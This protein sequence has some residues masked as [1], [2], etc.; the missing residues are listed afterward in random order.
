MG[1]LLTA[2]ICRTL[3]SNMRKLE[4]AGMPGSIREGYFRQALEKA[5]LVCVAEEKVAKK[6]DS[7]L[8]NPVKK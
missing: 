7:T 6:S 4:E 3:L 8:K 2:D 1:K 5:L